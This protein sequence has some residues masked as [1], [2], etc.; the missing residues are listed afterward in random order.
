MPYR[1]RKVEIYRT[2]FSMEKLKEKRGSLNI[3]SWTWKRRLTVCLG[4]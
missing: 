1:D 4:N 2:S 3:S